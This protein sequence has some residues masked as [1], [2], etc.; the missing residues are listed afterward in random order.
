MQIKTVY[1]LYYSA[2]G[3][4]AKVV[5]TVASA[6]AAALNAPLAHI[7]LTRPAQRVEVR[8]FGPDDLVVVGTPVYAGRVPNKLLPAFQTLLV[9]GG[10]LAVPVV[11]FGNR[12]FDDGLMELRNTLAAQGFCP[13]AAAAQP[14]QHAFTARLAAGRPNAGDLEAL[15]AFAQCAAEKILALSAAP[16]APVAVRGSDPVGPYYTPLGRDGKPVLFLKAKPRTNAALCTDCGI[17]AQVCPMGAISEEDVKEV[18]GVCIKCQAC[19]KRCPTHAKY[20]DDAAFLSH[21]EM[22]EATYTAPKAAEFFL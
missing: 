8:N 14:A 20:F 4:T 19:V 6:L 18:P 13:V 1:A 3:N 9:G 17:C 10:A 7:S 15:R 21:V 12:S 2:T 11:T 5:E 16:A 22:L